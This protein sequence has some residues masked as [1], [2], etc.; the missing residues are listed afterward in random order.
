MKSNIVAV[1]VIYN[2][3]VEDSITCKNILNNSDNSLGM[4]GS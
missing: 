1:I 2:K 3:K 4:L